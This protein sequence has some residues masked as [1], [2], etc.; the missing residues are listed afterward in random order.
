[1]TLGRRLRPLESNNLKLIDVTALRQDAHVCSR[2]PEQDSPS[3]RRAML[4]LTNRNISNVVESRL[5]PWP[6]WRKAHLSRSHL[7]KHDPLSRRAMPL[8]LGDQLPQNVRQNTAV[9]I[10]VHFYRRIDSQHHRNL[11]VL[12]VLTVNRQRQFLSRT[13][14]VFK[15]C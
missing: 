2:S 15:P 13:D 1:M 5:Q 6:S 14:A 9:L 11:L 4:M 3:G 10:V 12:A 7:Y 8:T